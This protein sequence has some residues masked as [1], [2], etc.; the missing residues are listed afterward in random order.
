MPVD[1]LPLD[2]LLPFAAVE[3]PTPAASTPIVAT[4][5]DDDES[6]TEEVAP[7]SSAFLRDAPFWLRE[8]Q[9]KSSCFAAARMDG[10][11]WAIIGYQDG[12]LDVYGSVPEQESPRMPNSPPQLNFPP[13][14]LLPPA[15]RSAAA[16]PR[17]SS[18]ASFR[19]IQSASDMSRA[20]TRTRRASRVQPGAKAAAT[21]SVSGLEA[22]VAQPPEAK[23]VL[24]PLLRRSED[25]PDN[26]LSQTAARSRESLEQTL[27]PAPSPDSD[28]ENVPDEHLQEKLQLRLTTVLRSKRGREVAQAEVIDSASL[29]HHANAPRTPAAIVLTKG[30]YGRDVH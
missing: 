3:W 15:G 12:S 7:P 9:K 4:D 11:S 25:H 20:S 1:A 13:I 6:D 8:R 14:S 5:P 28:S 26:L 19:S 23:G 2:F 21:L 10:T 27:S 18:A 16:R 29:L 24:S 22:F 30:G 17:M